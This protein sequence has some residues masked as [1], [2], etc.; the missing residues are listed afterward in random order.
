M[1][2]G[3]PINPNY[4]PGLIYNSSQ[5]NISGTLTYADALTKF[6]S[7]PIA[8]GTET[9]ANVIVADTLTA[10]QNIIMNGATGA[11][12]NYLQ[13]PD[14]S[15]Q[16]TA[17]TSVNFA[18]TNA[19][20]T[21][22]SQLS[23]NQPYQQIITGN[24]LSGNTNAPLVVKNQDTGE[25]FS[26]YI[27][28]STNYDATL[29]SNQATGGLTIRNQGGNSFTI[30]PTGNN[31]TFQNPINAL[32]NNI[33]TTGLITTGSLTLSNSGNTTNLATG[34]N[35]FNV[36]DPMVV[37]GSVSCNS[38]TLSNSGNTTDLT[39]TSTGLNINDPVTCNSLTTSGNIAT[40]GYLQLKTGA[41]STSAGCSNLGN[42]FQISTNTQIEGDLNTTTS[43]VTQGVLEGS[44]LQVIN[45][46]TLGSAVINGTSQLST[47]ANIAGSTI[48]TAGLFFGRNLEVGQN[49]FDIIAI[50]PTTANYLNIYGSQSSISQAD[51]PIISI[52]N[53]T[54]YLNGTQ[55]ATVGGTYGAYYVGQIIT[56]IFSSPPTGFLA[57]NGQHIPT[58]S[59]PS[60]FALI[61]TAYNAYNSGVPSGYYSM[62]NLVS[63]VPLG[64]NSTITEYGTAIPSYNDVAI[65]NNA[66]AGNNLQTSFLS[67]SHSISSAHS[68]TYGTG[69]IN[70]S[71]GSGGGTCA[72]QT[73]GSGGPTYYS[74][75]VV[76]PTT[77]TGNAGGSNVS[78]LSQFLAVYY[79]IYGGS[80]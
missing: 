55:I 72:A 31:A 79:Y 44:T 25:Y 37:T 11:S 13:F 58:S 12:G 45:N 63:A 9:L 56:G 66:Q 7:F 49:E 51:T 24:S 18:K 20:N 48:N 28:P 64:A 59:Y 68:H 34:P 47:N 52:A 39:T 3:I 75:S 15:K 8:Q 29:Y 6:L 14:G 41:Y 77:S 40:S 69:F 38:L 50:N 33:T 35:G 10:S 57:C 74:T 61:G 54:A 46:A 32:G 30:N 62:P 16:T 5:Y 70:V 73:G 2:T 36:F 27:D 76:T 26:F 80:P 65:L 42:V 67:H 53:G 19:S 21:F 1:T 22:L 23:P 17:V 78:N 71:N 43:V 4:F 60:L